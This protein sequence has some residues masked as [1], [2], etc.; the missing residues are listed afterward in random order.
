MGSCKSIVDK[1]DIFEMFGLPCFNTRRHPK[2]I[3]K[4]RV[5][6]KNLVETEIY[7]VETLR[8]KNYEY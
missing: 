7:L 8:R 3:S 4:R 2:T 5:P 1:R 6:L